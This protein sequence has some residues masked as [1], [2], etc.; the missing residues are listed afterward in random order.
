[1]NESFHSSPGWNDRVASFTSGSLFHTTEWLEFL[2]LTQGVEPIV[3]PFDAGEQAGFNVGAKLRKGPFSVIGSPLP[4]WTTVRMGPLFDPHDIAADRLAAEIDAFGRA[5]RV[6]M[7]E[8]ASEHL[9][10]EAMTAAGFEQQPD[11]TMIVDLAEDEDA[12]W[13]GM[14]STARNRV[15]KGRD[16]GL[17][18]EIGLDDEIVGDVWERVEAIFHHQQLVVPYDRARVQAVYDALAP[19]DRLVGLRVRAPDGH[20]AAC[21][22]FPFDHETIFFWAGAARAEDRAL[23]PNELMHFE[24]MVHARGLGLNRY[25]M[26][27]GGD[28]KKK[29]GAHPVQNPHWIRYYNPAARAGRVAVSSA[30]RTKRAI[31]AKLRGGRQRGDS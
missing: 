8:V 12:I 4:G 7:L 11:A 10:P 16:N 25:D 6:S 29:F 3:S 18:V 24:L 17:T 23:V 22:L 2:R 31:A 9:D 26:C 14:R 20:I 15:R 28:Y 1:M 21:G 5:Q 13:N 27:G 19:A 30:I